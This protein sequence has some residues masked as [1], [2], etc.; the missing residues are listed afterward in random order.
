MTFA[1]NS[2]QPPLEFIPPRFNPLVWQRAKTALPLWLRLRTNI[3]QIRANNLEV[4]LE[5][6]QEFE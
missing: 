6:Y 2:V 3:T 5:K 4:L 1:L